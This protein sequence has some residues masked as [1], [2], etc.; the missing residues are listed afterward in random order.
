MLGLIVD[1][2]GAGFVLMLTAL[3]FPIL[4]HYLIKWID[5]H[6]VCKPASQT[7]TRGS[8]TNPAQSPDNSTTPG[9]GST[10]PV[11]L[12]CPECQQGRIIEDRSGALCGHCGTEFS[13]EQLASLRASLR[14]ETASAAT[15]LNSHQEATTSR[16]KPIPKQIELELEGVRIGWMDTYFVNILGTLRQGP[17]DAYY[18]PEPDHSEFIGYFTSLDKAQAAIEKAYL[19]AQHQKQKSQSSQTGIR[20]RPLN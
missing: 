18:L 3:A 5:E 7:Q 10:N 4:K 19:K 13:A 15:S 16:D 12:S 11:R 9:V 20:R 1:L 6:L 14:S 8:Q 2:L 17:V